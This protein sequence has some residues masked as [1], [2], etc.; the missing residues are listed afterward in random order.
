MLVSMTAF[1]IFCCVF[2]LGPGLFGQTK[3]EVTSPLG[4]KF[5]SIPDEKKVVPEAQKALAAEPKNPDLMLKLALAQSSI[6]EYRES[7]AT[8][9]RGL[10]I[11]PDN[12]ALDRERGHREVG[13]R[14]FSKAR[15]D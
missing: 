4:T 6:R 13:L 3:L 7:V 2:S 5:Y 1:R 10:A 15:A 11:A 9:A 14:E 8:C 12:A